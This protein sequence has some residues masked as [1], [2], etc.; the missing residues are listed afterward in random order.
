VEYAGDRATVRQIPLDD[1]GQATIDLS[2]IGVGVTS[3]VLAVSGLAPTTL[4]PARYTL[5]VQAASP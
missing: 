2:S 1:S 4:Q 5:D 3:A